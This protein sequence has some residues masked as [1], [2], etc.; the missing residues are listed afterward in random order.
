DVVLPV[1]FQLDGHVEPRIGPHASAP[2]LDAGR[3]LGVSDAPAL[4]RHA[5]LA[6]RKPLQRMKDHLVAP[7]EHRPEGER[8]RM[9]IERE[10]PQVDRVRYL[11]EQAA[12]VGDRPLPVY[13][14]AG[15]VELLPGAQI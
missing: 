6:P 9:V 8:P 5:V 3:S 12:T 7:G 15:V 13:Q 1:P 14:K 11:D 2:S 4:E 10:V